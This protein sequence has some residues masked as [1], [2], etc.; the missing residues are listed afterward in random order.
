MRWLGWPQ[1]AR[2]SSRWRTILQSHICSPSSPGQPQHNHPEAIQTRTLLYR[3]IAARRS[4]TLVQIGGLAEKFPIVMDNLAIEQDSIPDGRHS[5]IFDPGTGEVELPL[6]NAVHQ[7]DAGNRGRG[8]PEPFEAGHH[9]PSG[10]DVSMVL[11]D[12]VVQVL[13]GPDLRVLSQQAIGLHFTHRPMRSSI[14]IERD[15]LRRLALMFDR[16]SERGFGRAHVA[17]PRA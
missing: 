16:L 11:L 14:A 8:A 6:A 17:L 15:R 3:D 1:S 13:R 4:R 9:V 10:L 5:G 12:H 7:L 2:E